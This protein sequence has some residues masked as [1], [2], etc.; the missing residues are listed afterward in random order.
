MRTILFLTTVVVLCATIAAQSAEVSPQPTS[1]PAAKTPAE[2]AIDRAVAAIAK[3]PKSVQAHN[4]LAWG[5]VRRARETGDPEYYTRAESAV[6]RSLEIESGNFEAEKL[7]IW[8]RLGLHDFVVAM[9]WAKALQKRAPDDVLV[10]GF[11]VD[12]TMEL[13]RYKEA[14]EACQWMLDIRPGNI[15]A[16]TRTAYLREVFGDVDGA[17][18]AMRQ[19]YHAVAPRETEDRAWILTHMAHLELSRGDVKTAESLAADAL[20]IFPDYHYALAQWALVKTAQDRHD[21]AVEILK[22]RCAIAPHPENFLD[23]G[24]AVARAG[25]RHEAAHIFADF[26]ES[27]A[28]ESNG[29]DNCNRE[30]A[31]YLLEEG[32]QP[33]KGLEIAKKEAGFRRDVKTLDLLAWALYKNGEFEAAD[34]AMHECLATGVQD[35]E[36]FFHAGMIARK[37]GDFE[38]SRR[39]L[40]RSVMLHPKSVVARDVRA[41]LEK[42]GAPSKS[43]GAPGAE[44]AEERPDRDE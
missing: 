19:A 13:G 36:F 8:I 26:E 40:E 35:A 16:L 39:Y 20:K 34:D 17:L 2:L 7:R 21:E 44:S 23:L 6:A 42:M 30:F 33:K 22:K 4:G 3:N 9:Q 41:A 15:P 25:D 32:R 1:L 18:D 37:S 28:A 43:S 12:A 11:I 27:A 29:T 38:T 10:Y 5:Y 14:E 31:M 24:R